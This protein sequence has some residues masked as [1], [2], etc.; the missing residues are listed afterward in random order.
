MITD[1]YR[2]LQMIIDD[3]RW[4]WTSIDDFV[5]REMYNAYNALYTYNIHKH[6][7]YIYI[8]TYL[9][10]AGACGRRPG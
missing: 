5:D 4:S 8:Y 9:K 1:D 7:S 3:Y 2:W 10:Q 6:I